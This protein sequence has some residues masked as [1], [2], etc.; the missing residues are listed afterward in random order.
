PPRDRARGRRGGGGA[1]LAR[2]VP[3]RDRSLGLARARRG[4]GARVS[5]ALVAARS[6]RGR[7]FGPGPDALSREARGAGFRDS[8]PDAPAHPARARPARRRRAAG[9]AGGPDLPDARRPLPRGV[10]RGYRL[11]DGKGAPRRPVRRGRARDDA[12]AR[13]AAVGGPYRARGSGSQ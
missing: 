6:R 7:P 3:A 4:P 12:P 10:A 5:V 9:A 11:R 8:F 1:V 2:T 13:V